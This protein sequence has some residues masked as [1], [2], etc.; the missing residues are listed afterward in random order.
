MPRASMT[1]SRQWAA[2]APRESGDIAI[3]AR[4]SPRTAPVVPIAVAKQNS[5]HTVHRHP[6]REEPPALSA[7]FDIP[8]GTEANVGTR[9]KRW[10]KAPMCTP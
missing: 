10:A 4:T 3:T 8:A 5:G 9:V 2:P 7:Q 6:G 1:F